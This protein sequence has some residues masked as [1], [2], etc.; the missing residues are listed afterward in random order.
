MDKSTREVQ[1]AQPLQSNSKQF[2]IGVTILTSNKG[3]FNVT[4]KNKIFHFTKSITDDDFNQITF[5]PEPP[6]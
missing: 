5:P 2:K 1:L 3:N 6:K 4:N